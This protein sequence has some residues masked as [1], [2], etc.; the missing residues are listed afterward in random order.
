MGS[1]EMARENRNRFFEQVLPKAKIIEEQVEE[2]EAHKEDLAQLEDIHKM[3]KEARTGRTREIVADMDGTLR[4]IFTGNM[5]DWERIYHID[6]AHD[7]REELLLNLLRIVHE[8]VDAMD[9]D[10]V[11]SGPP[12]GVS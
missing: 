12:L 2:D 5:Q 10:Q 6:L 11:G 8:A 3:I 4:K 9:K 1:I 7:A